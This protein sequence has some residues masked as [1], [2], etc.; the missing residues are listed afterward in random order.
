MQHVLRQ[1]EF[2]EYGL[3]RDPADWT[4]EKIAVRAG[5]IASDKG[6]EGDFDD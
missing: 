2:D 6:P 5:G 4:P 3:L 1:P